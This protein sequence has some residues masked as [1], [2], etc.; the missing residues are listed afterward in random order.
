[1]FFFLVLNVIVSAKPYF[2]EVNW[3]VHKMLEK[4]LFLSRYVREVVNKN[5]L[6]CKVNET[7]EQHNHMKSSYFVFE[8]I[9]TDAA[10]FKGKN[11]SKKTF[12]NDQL[13]EDSENKFKMIVSY[14]CWLN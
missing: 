13:H 1:M 14:E 2:F 9:F 11:V 7:M 10:S 8:Y 12:R 6:F 4:T 5:W 3:S